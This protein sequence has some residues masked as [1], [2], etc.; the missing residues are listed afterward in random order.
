MPKVNSNPFTQNSRVVAATIVNA[1][2]FIASDA[3]TS[4]TNTIKLLT[5]GAEGTIVKTITIASNDTSARNIA[6]YYSGD[7]GS[8][9]Y[10]LA[11]IPVPASSGFN[12]TS[13]NVDVLASAVFN[14]LP[15]DQSGRP[16]I[17]LGA[18][19]E[20]YIGVITSAVTAN[21][22]VYVTAQLEDF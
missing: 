13:S 19:Q 8:T 20:I 1:T 6:I 5:A 11:T 2:S 22:N 21:K 9:K 4:P 15:V 16:V 12:S 7:S 18:S 17:L 10:L 3:G 14:G